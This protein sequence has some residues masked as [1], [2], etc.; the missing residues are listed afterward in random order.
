MGGLMSV[1]VIVFFMMYTTFTSLFSSLDLSHIYAYQIQKLQMVHIYVLIIRICFTISLI[2]SVLYLVLSLYL[3]HQ[4]HRKIYRTTMFIGLITLV[5]LLFC[6]GFMMT[7]N[8]LGAFTHELNN[9]Q[10]SVLK[11]KYDY[12]VSLMTQ[13]SGFASLLS[14]GKAFVFSGL[15]GFSNLFLHAIYLLEISGHVLL[16]SEDLKL[17][18][19]QVEKILRQDEK[20]KIDRHTFKPTATSEMDAKTIEFASLKDIPHYYEPHPDFAYR[21][22]VRKSVPVAKKSFVALSVCIGIIIS[23]MGGYAAYDK[24]FNYTNL[25][26]IS[27]LTFAYGGESGSGYI[28]NFTTNISYDDNTKVQE[29]MKSVKYH[30]DTRQNLSNGDEI[31]ILA[32][33][34]K[35]LAKRYR[36]HI[37]KDSKTYK[38]AGL[39][40]RFDNG[41]KVSKSVQKA[42]KSDA[43]EAFARAFSGRYHNSSSYSYQFESL[44]FAK[45]NKKS[46]DGDYAIGV[47][48]VTCS[49]KE[50]YFIPKTVSYDLYTYVGGVNSNYTRVKSSLNYRTPENRIYSAGNVFDEVTVRTKLQ[51]Y[52]PHTTL[53]KMDS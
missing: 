41:S 46:T 12:I 25:D 28:T 29:F 32:T 35:A 20:I 44:W 14:R 9:T 7:L 30:Y 21:E 38:V 4:T 19:N 15:V 40:Y 26:L 17:S 22:H 11:E 52:F 51:K 42:I 31:T 49:Y 24:Y 37:L 33:Y 43:K 13:S 10:L 45:G 39:V 6:I 1:M 53:S 27:G 47:F 18:M 2:L 16:E 36:I 34:D 48:R 5:S 23:C 8:N 50:F 3:F